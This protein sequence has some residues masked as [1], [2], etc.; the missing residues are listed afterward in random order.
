MHLLW[1]RF[2]HLNRRV[3]NERKEGQVYT[4]NLERMYSSII[5]FLGPPFNAQSTHIFGN[6]KGRHC[7]VGDSQQG[8][9][10][11]FFVI[12]LVITEKNQIGFNKDFLP[13]AAGSTV[14]TQRPQ[15]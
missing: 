1:L 11:T 12:M 9:T 10:K 13:W 6:P 8:T 4:C 2:P 5:S 15:E 14:D 3:V 7:N